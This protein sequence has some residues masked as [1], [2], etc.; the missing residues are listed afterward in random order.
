MQIPFSELPGRHERDYRRRLENP[1]FDEP[2]EA[3]DEVL[4][5]VQRRDHEELI[6]FIGELREVVGR[7]VS[8]KP[9]EETE[10]VLAI[11][12]DLERLYETCAGLADDQEGNRSAIRELLE[13]I[14]RTVRANAQGDA[15][16]A[17]ELETEEQAR[18]LHFELLNQPLVADLLHPDSLIG[19]DDLLP[20]LL[21][22]SEAAL[23]AALQ[24]FDPE[25]RKQIAADARALLEGRDPQ[26]QRP[27]AWQRLD[28]LTA[29]LS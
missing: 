15:L 23:A 26:Q 1:L 21:S 25:Q 4:L 12:E 14:M 9:Q 8:L 27:A 18:T 11:K 24:L 19:P 22:E 16:A 7:A 29:Q 10:V 28:Q 3:E 20:S 17:Q 13:V 5:D 2:A 6:A